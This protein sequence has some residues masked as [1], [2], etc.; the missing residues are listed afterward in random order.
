MM[1]FIAFPL[2]FPRTS[3][4]PAKAAAR[5]VLALGCEV[6]D[7]QMM[8][9]TELA[10]E[11]RVS[12]SLIDAINC[13]FANCDALTQRTPMKSTLKPASPVA[14]A[15]YRQRQSKLTEGTCAAIFFVV[16]LIVLAI[17]GA[18]VVEAQGQEIRVHEISRTFVP[19]SQSWR[20]AM[21]LEGISDNDI[22]DMEITERSR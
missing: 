21:K 9:L 5:V 6:D 1:R 18:K 14:P 12:P 2:A 8:T 4:V 13:D 10:W 19:G 20:D 15:F 7:A 16:T 3:R 11:G 22:H 17:G